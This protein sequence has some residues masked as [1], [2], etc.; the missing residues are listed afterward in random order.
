MDNSQFCPDIAV[1]SQEGETVLLVEVKRSAKTDYNDGLVRLRAYCQALEKDVFLMLVNTGQY[2]LWN[3]SSE[4]PIYT[5]ATPL[6]LANYIDLQK[7]P[8][9]QLDGYSFASVVYSWLGSV[10]FKDSATLLKM[11]TQKW[12]VESGIHQQIYRGYIHRERVLA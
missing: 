3:S 9:T 6:L 10:I 2:W 4:E 8:L 11:P 12:L 7:V 1:T 5:G